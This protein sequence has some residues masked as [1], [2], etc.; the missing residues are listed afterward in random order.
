MELPKGVHS[1]VVH[2]YMEYETIL[3]LS[4]FLLL[5]MMPMLSL[6]VQAVIA[7]YCVQNF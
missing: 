6:C 3:A 5:L 2:G 4:L 1:M 7:L